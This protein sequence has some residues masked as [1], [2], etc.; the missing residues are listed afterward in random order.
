M[1]LTIP[2]IKQA[3][4]KLGYKWSTKSI[5]L[6]GIR[7][8]L[9]VPN[10][11]NDLMVAAWTQ[12]AMPT[13]L[14]VAQQQ[15]FLN[16]FFYTDKNG[17]VLAEDGDAG[18][19]T[20]YALAQLKATVGTECW[21]SWVMTTVPGLFYLQNPLKGGCAVCAPGQHLN[22]WKL[23]LHQNNPKFPALVQH[24]AEIRYY[25]DNDR[26]NLAEETGPIHSGYIGLNCHRS[27][28]VGVTAKIDSWSA[29]CQV[30]NTK[31]NHDQLL[32]VCGAYK[33]A[34]NNLFTYTLLTEKQ[35][36]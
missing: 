26:D 18:P 19:A 20:Q 24:G 22:V 32:R 3:F 33:E 16:Q 4:A 17:K 34:N 12:P 23:G 15:G 11:F 8:T 2:L 7:T 5:N 27:G 31:A 14:I 9:Q 28:L 30:F 10:T 29:G 35:L 6:V 1:N 36:A 25:R 13:G 21:K